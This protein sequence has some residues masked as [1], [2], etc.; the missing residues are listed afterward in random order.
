MDG[1]GGSFENKKFVRVQHRKIL[2]SFN[3][4]FLV[5]FGRYLQKLFSREKICD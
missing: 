3:I 1:T 4:S 2:E 5:I